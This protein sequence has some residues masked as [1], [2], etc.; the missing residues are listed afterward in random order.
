MFSAC[1]KLYKI[2]Y[3]QDICVLVPSQMFDVR[4]ILLEMKYFQDFSVH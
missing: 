4:S 3:F 1:F 2:W